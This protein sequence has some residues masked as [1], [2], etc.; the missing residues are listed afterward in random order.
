MTVGVGLSYDRAALDAAIKAVGELVTFDAAALMEEIGALGESQT[1]RRITDEKTAPDGTP[2]PPNLEGTS[3]LLRTGQ[4]L[5]ASVGFVSTADE[6][7]WGAAW[8]F[9][10]IHQDGAVITPKTA[11]ALRFKLGGKTL[12]AK[13]VTIPARPFVGI[14]DE[15]RGELLEL[16][17][18]H[19]GRLSPGGARP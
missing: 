17:T 4:N 15:N 1:R 18:D 2:W 14:S 16:V 9:A 3:T 6:A 11:Q 19:F 8:E 10:H 12:H 7:E 13:S 5:L